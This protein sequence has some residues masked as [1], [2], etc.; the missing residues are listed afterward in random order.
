M[1]VRW[2]SLVVLSL[3]LVI[4]FC[5]DNEILVA[6][7]DVLGAVVMSMLGRQFMMSNFI[8]NINS[9]WTLPHLSFCIVTYTAIHYNQMGWCFSVTAITYLSRSPASTTPN[10]II[11]V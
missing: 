8:F 11:Q 2:N 4:A 10:F 7:C 3:L 5:S 9:F 6:N 1:W